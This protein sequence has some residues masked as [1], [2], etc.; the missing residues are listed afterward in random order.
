MGQGILDPEI[1]QGQFLSE[2]VSNGVCLLCSCTI[3]EVDMVGGRDLTNVLLIVTTR[4]AISM[5]YDGDGDEHALP[6]LRLLLSSSVTRLHFRVGWRGRG[7]I[8]RNLG[9]WNGDGTQGAAWIGFIAERQR[10][11]SGGGELWPVQ[12]MF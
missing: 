3:L 10:N 8:V 9:R 11:S 1:D 2:S 5:V 7:G 12:G 6:H 4:Y